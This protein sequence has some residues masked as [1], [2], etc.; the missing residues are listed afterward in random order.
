LNKINLGFTRS[1]DLWRGNT[2]TA[3]INCDKQIISDAKKQFE[4]VFNSNPD[5]VDE[6]ASKIEKEISVL[7]SQ[8]YGLRSEKEVKR[9]FSKFIILEEV[10]N[11][12]VILKIARITK[13]IL[14]S[15]NRNMVRKDDLL[16][17]LV[18]HFLSDNKLKFDQINQKL[19]VLNT[20]TN[21]SQ[22]LSNLI[23]S[24][25]IEKESDY[26]KLKV[27]SLF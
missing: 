24:G 1:T 18:L 4:Q 22:L 3:T 27:L 23:C 19:S 7:F 13:A 6:L 11:R 16:M 21:L 8:Y 9:L 17:A 10:N 20:A 12:V 26:Y 2:E 15:S 25:F 5:V 14:A